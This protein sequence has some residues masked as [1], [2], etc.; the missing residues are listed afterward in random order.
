MSALASARED[1][2]LARMNAAKIRQQSMEMTSYM[3][4]S[5][6]TIRG[7]SRT[8]PPLPQDTTADAVITVSSDKISVM[9]DNPQHASTET[10]KDLKKRIKS[11][12]QAK[13]KAENDLARAQ[14]DLSTIRDRAYFS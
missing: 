6:P 11:L 2:K 13:L 12:E 7:G 5:V 14:L 3:S 1:A 9:D 10:I 4:M 8:T